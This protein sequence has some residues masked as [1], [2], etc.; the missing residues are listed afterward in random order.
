MGGRGRGRETD[1]QIATE[2]DRETERSN[3]P[4]HGRMP[5]TPAPHPSCVCV[6]N[7]LGISKSLYTFYITSIR[8]N[9]KKSGQAVKNNGGD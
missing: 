5:V 8:Y 9:V 3:K 6:Y 7:K 2:T 4:R 1:R